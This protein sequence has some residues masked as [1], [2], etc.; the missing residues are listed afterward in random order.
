MHMISKLCTHNIKAYKQTRQSQHQP[1]VHMYS[2][3]YLF[4]DL[5][6]RY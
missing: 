4:T 3:I 2:S 6:D 1:N 5:N